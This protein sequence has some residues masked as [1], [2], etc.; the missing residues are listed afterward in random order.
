MFILRTILASALACTALAS[1]VPGTATPVIPTGTPATV[2]GIFSLS[3]AV[4]SG[5]GQLI[6]L[7][8]A[9]GLLGYYAYSDPTTGVQSCVADATCSTPNNLAQ[10]SNGR[11]TCQCARGFMIDF[12]G[13]CES[14][15]LAS[16]Q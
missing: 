2:P 13:G 11:S 12:F 14:A 16:N 8:V 5:G 10:L 9:A 15:C 1:P 4:L 3:Q 7:N 6:N